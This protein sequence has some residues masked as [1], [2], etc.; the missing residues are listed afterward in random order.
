MPS[1]T[2]I[3]PSGLC[4]H[5][6][7]PP[8]YTCSVAPGSD[9]KSPPNLNTLGVSSARLQYGR[10][11]PPTLPSSPPLS[12]SSLTAAPSTTQPWSYTA[13]WTYNPIFACCSFTPLSS[14]ED[15]S[16]STSSPTLITAANLSTYAVAIDQG[17]QQLELSI[18]YYT[19]DTGSSPSSA[20]LVPPS[21]TFQ[22][23]FRFLD[24]SGAYM[25]INPKAPSPTPTE[26]S[27]APPSIGSQQIEDDFR[28]GEA[29][30][31]FY[32]SFDAVDMNPVRIPVGA[33]GVV[34]QVLVPSTRTSFCFD[35]F[36]LRIVEGAFH[37]STESLLQKILI[38]IG[39]TVVFNAAIIPVVLFYGLPGWL[40]RSAP[41]N[42]FQK[43]PVVD[44]YV[45]LAL[46]ISTCQ[47][48]YNILLSYLGGGRNW[49]VNILHSSQ[50]LWLIPLVLVGVF[51][52]SAFAHWCLFLCYN[53]I[54]HRPRQHRNHAPARRWRAPLLG[55]WA[56]ICLTCARAGLVALGIVQ[57]S[58]WSNPIGILL[59]VPETIAMLSVSIFF[60]KTMWLLLM[61]GRRKS[62][63]NARNGTEFGSSSLSTG[64]SSAGSAQTLS[65]IKTRRFGRGFG[66]GVT[67]SDSM[68]P[69]RSAAARSAG[70]MGDEGDEDN[71]SHIATDDP[72]SDFI[73]F[74]SYHH[75]IYVR[76]LLAFEPKLCDSTGHPMDGRSTV[77]SQNSKATRELLSNANND[78]N[79]RYLGSTL[80]TS[81]VSRSSSTASS[82]TQ[83]SRHASEFEYNVQEDLS[84]GIPSPPAAGTVASQDRSY[85]Q[86]GPRPPNQPPQRNQR[87]Q[88]VGLQSGGRKGGPGAPSEK[89]AHSTQG[90]RFSAA[91]SSNNTS[92]S[93]GVPWRHAPPR[94]PLYK[95]KYS[96]RDGVFVL[97]SNPNNAK[98]TWNS[99]TTSYTTVSQ[100]TNAT[101]PS[102]RAAVA[103][104][105][106]AGAAATTANPSPW[107]YVIFPQR[108]VWPLIKSTY[109]LFAR[110]P[111]RILVAALT[112]LVLC[113]DVLLTIGGAETA[114]AVPVSCL[115]GAI[116]YPG[117]LQF[118]NTMN[119]ARAMHTVN[120]VLI[121]VLLP[122]VICIT[123]LHQIRMVQKYNWCLRLLRIGNYDFVP[124]GR[125]YT[126][127]LKHP[128]R[129]IGYTVGFGVVGLSFTVFL[130]FTLCTVVAM[131]LVAATFRS[132]IFRSLSS[133]A[134]AA[135]GIT[136]VLIL[137]L[138]LVQMLMIK[139][140]FRMRG[141]RFLISRQASFHHWEFYW[142]FFNIVFGAFSF[143]KRILL[144]ILSMSVYSTRIDLC[145]MGGRFRP[146]DGGYSAFVGL[147][148]A[149]HVHNNPILL[150]FVQILRD[151]LDE[152]RLPHWKPHFI[153]AR[154]ERNDQDRKRQEE[155]MRQRQRQL[156][157]DSGVAVE[158]LQTKSGES[159]AKTGAQ[160]E[161][162]SEMERRRMMLMMMN[163]EPPQPPSKD[164]T[165]KSGVYPSDRDRHP[166]LSNIDETEEDARMDDLLLAVEGPV[167]TK[168]VR[169]RGGEAA[170]AQISKVYHYF[171]MDQ[172]VPRHGPGQ[173][174]LGA[175]APAQGQGIRT[176]LS[177]TALPS[178]T[179][180]SPTSDNRKKNNRISMIYSP[181]LSQDERQAAAE[182]AALAA[183]ETGRVG[184]GREGSFEN[185]VGG[186][187]AAGRIHVK[188]VPHDRNLYTDEPMVTQEEIQAQVS[189]AR[190]R[191]IRARNRWF[192]YVTLIRNPSLCA[193]RRT[194]NEDY[195]HPIAKDGGVNSDG[196]YSHWEEQ[197]EDIRWDRED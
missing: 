45:P 25:V 22:V 8:N 164:G 169:V 54:M 126:Q 152:R 197:L 91:S 35:Y 194:P 116:A 189:E 155:Q 190:Q 193:L 110:L 42:F 61:E 142:A 96:S 38:G 177:P 129:F 99:A 58:F 188:V 77:G 191:S 94:P 44:H 63:K 10:L 62:G 149:D 28:P 67:R 97:T 50:A 13:G 31:L 186:G 165:A 157:K 93:S 78:T 90:T 176:P 4:I 179:P 145:I 101:T 51:F 18:S 174:P 20:A 163:P 70:D 128:V 108:H 106:V 87:L 138:W 172:R 135:L 57:G 27:T 139:Y 182:A 187:N 167:G 137:I 29:E 24:G 162:K 39:S 122:T 33:R 113:Y 72:K 118:D 109:L 69:L 171:R 43:N 26:N 17:Q 52:A 80:N 107:E 9:I 161:S 47:W 115:L 74:S 180:V 183:A 32:Y 105:T 117:Q 185:E 178:S 173:G 150:E 66:F 156:Q 3:Y 136:C 68:T 79:T 84:K 121:V 15:P 119:V 154:R 168:G 86:V 40:W 100:Q 166:F 144:T 81:V 23:A 14:S 120:L 53:Q 83:Y 134:I 11:P 95:N 151:L 130:L 196:M 103:S 65:G 125:G 75:R 112:T 59:A 7:L 140:R 143:C 89:S 133:R 127:H 73:N 36:A 30:N 37:P 181:L 148:L 6:N 147:V 153:E 102:T 141:S 60:L 160:G 184:K 195:L 5:P 192:L 111:L 131:L 48:I 76:S 132:S 88:Y 159:G 21:D 175:R 170:G 16:N 34:V 85:L 56:S 124:G 92:N 49:S 98:L 114:L 123:V 146:W 55:F 82:A 64:M 19:S 41:V 1:H 12:G 71:T 158:C 46:F 2:T 104:A